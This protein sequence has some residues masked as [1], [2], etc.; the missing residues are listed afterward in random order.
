MALPDGWGDLTID[1]L[2][3]DFRAARG[4]RPREPEGTDLLPLLAEFRDADL[5]RA[6]LKDFF[7]T[8]LRPHGG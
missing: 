6:H 3:V 2:S 4:D 1:D 8:Q 5:E 7:E